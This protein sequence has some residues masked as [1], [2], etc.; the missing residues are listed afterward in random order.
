MIANI[1]KL[2]ASC[3]LTILVLTLAG[4]ARASTV[5]GNPSTDGGWTAQGNSL[6]KG[7]YSDG[8]GMYSVTISNTA[9]VLDPS[10]PLIS[11]AGGFNWSAGDTIVGI[12]G[13][14]V[15]T[16][17]AAGGWTSYAAGSIPVNS[18]LTYDGTGTLAGATSTRIVAKYAS[19]TTTWKTSTVAPKSGNG[20][21]SLGGAGNG[22]ILLG[23]NPYDFSP[24][25]SGTL[26]PPTDSPLEQTPSG[27]IAIS[28]YFGRVITEWS[29]STLVA[30]ESY[31]DLTLLQNTLASSA[32]PTTVV[33][34][35]AVDLDLQRGTGDVTDAITTLPN[36]VPEP[37]S[38]SVLGFA[39]LLVGRRRRIA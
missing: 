12:G 31:L 24:A 22:A 27:Q 18:D 32:N 21:A 15:S 14:F 6:D 33:L 26:I 35:D 28:P 25:D 29:G 7:I 20:V 37:T 4:A 39:G 5:T 30:F 16:T 10:S 34:G 11:S 38:L 36:A 19:P 23:T 3:L 17:A 13:N 8:A 9:F 1:K 2:I